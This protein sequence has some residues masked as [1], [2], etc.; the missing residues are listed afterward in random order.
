MKTKSRKA[1]RAIIPPC[2]LLLVIGWQLCP[3]QNV[4]LR[5]LIADPSHEFNAIS[6]CPSN[7][8]IVVNFIGTNTAA[9][10]PR[11]IIRTE[12]QL[13]NLYDNIGPAFTNWHQGAWQNYLATNGAAMDTRRMQLVQQR[14]AI[15]ANIN[16][17]SNAVDF[18]AL[19][20]PLIA[21]NL[22]RL[23]QLEERLGR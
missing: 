12:T 18:T 3:A 19:S 22:V 20:A 11:M 5:P 21:S 14:E 2:I 7:W 10:A 9:P 4:A 15:L 6:G 1:S 13:A 17:L 23:R 16:S 8:P